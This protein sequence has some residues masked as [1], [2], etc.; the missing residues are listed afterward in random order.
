[1]ADRI[2]NAKGL[3]QVWYFNIDL[4]EERE[5]TKV[6]GERSF[7]TEGRADAKALW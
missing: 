7:Q 4:K 6:S 1:M 2:R 3:T 5:V